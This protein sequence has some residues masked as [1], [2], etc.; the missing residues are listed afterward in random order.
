MCDQLP[1]SYKS[2]PIYETTGVFPVVKINFPLSTTDIPIH[3]D[4]EGAY[5]LLPYALS[6]ES[7]KFYAVGTLSKA[8]TT[9]DINA[10]GMR[11]VFEFANASNAALGPII[12]SL[13]DKVNAIMMHNVGHDDGQVLV[14]NE[15]GVC[16]AFIDHGFSVQVN[17]DAF[18]GTWEGRETPNYF[19]APN[20]IHIC[21]VWAELFRKKE[22]G[23]Y[24]RFEDVWLPAGFYGSLHDMANALTANTYMKGERNGAVYKFEVS[25]KRPVLRLIAHHRQPGASWLRLTPADGSKAAGVTEEGKMVLGNRKFIDFKFSPK[26]LMIV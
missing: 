19:F 5:G 17:I 15:F 10:L 7:F 23:S 6:R 20:D 24:E 14:F 18:V 4:L 9:Y 12:F 1:S 3:F 16:I 8:V 22:A 26:T 25:A 21:S 13:N 2:P 11:Y